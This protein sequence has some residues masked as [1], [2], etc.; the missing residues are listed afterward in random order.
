MPLKIERLK[1]IG[2]ECVNW[3]GKRGKKKVEEKMK[4]RRKEKETKLS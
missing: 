4:E 1:M 3:G 2:G